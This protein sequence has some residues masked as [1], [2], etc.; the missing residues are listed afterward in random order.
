MFTASTA[1]Y[2]RD[3]DLE[4]SY[5]A[6]VVKTGDPMWSAKKRL[7]VSGLWSLQQPTTVDAVEHKAGQTHQCHSRVITLCRAGLPVSPQALEAGNDWFCSQVRIYTTKFHCAS[8]FWE[9]N[10]LPPFVGLQPSKFG[11]CSSQQSGQDALSR[12]YCIQQ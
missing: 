9:L 5:Y 12:R 4:L 8:P 3:L 1:T 6:R 11:S 2:S 10:S 7:Q